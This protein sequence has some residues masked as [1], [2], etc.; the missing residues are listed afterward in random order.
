MPSP[1]KSRVTPDINNPS[2]PRYPTPKPYTSY[3]D[4][5]SPSQ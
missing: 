4:H 5:Q 3:H 2:L 1:V